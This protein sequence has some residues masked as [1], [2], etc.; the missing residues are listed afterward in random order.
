MRTETIE[1]G[2]YALAVGLVGLLGWQVYQS[3]TAPWKYGPQTKQDWTK[4]RSD[5]KTKGEAKQPDDTQWR[6]TKSYLEWWKLVEESNWTGKLPPKP[7]EATG[8][9]EPTVDKPALRVEPLTD[10]VELTAILAGVDV[11]R[12]KVRYKK[13]VQLPDSDTQSMDT[14]TAGGATMPSSEGQPYQDLV[15]GDRLYKPFDPIVFSSIDFTDVSAVFTRPAAD[16]KGK[17]LKEK[18]FLEELALDRE[19]V[20]PA[21]V[22]VMGGKTKVSERRPESSGPRWEDPGDKTRMVKQNVWMISSHD[23]ERIAEDYNTIMTEEFVTTDYQARHKGRNGKRIKGVQFG[24][25]S[26]NVARFGI[27][28]G[29]VLIKVNGQAVTGKSNAINVGRKQFDRGIRSFDLT[30]LSNGREVVRTYRAPDRK[31]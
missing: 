28:R 8:N 16:G 27:K 4:L 7:V 10:I 20:D 24:G 30:F 3:R 11:F 26:R 14:V 6:Y 5:L 13:P 9:K 29:D 2:I 17:P 19:H 23:N 22:K 25:V 21:L 18:L 1:L 31:K 12:V 15:A